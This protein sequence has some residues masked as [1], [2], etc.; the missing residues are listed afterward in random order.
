[1]ANGWG[2]RREGAGRKKGEATILAEKLK[3]AIA[4]KVM[5]R[6]DELVDPL[7]ERVVQDGDVSAFNALMDRGFG[8]PTQQ[9]EMDVET[10]KLI[11]DDSPKS[12][13][14]STIQVASPILNDDDDDK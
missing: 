4:K 2:G 7:L 13:I 5:D 9:V 12:A 10:R 1:M 11:E 14:P 3:D 6:V 8:R